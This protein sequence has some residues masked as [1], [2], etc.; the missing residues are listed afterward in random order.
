MFRVRFYDA[1]E[2]IMKWKLTR[3]RSLKSYIEEG[4]CRVQELAGKGGGGGVLR[5]PARLVQK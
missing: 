5:L 3:D 1:N 4:Y 2:Y